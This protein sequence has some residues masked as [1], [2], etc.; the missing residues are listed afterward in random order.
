MAFQ[1]LRKEVKEFYD[2][3]YDIL[4]KSDFSIPTFLAF[5]AALQLLSL[6]YLPLHLSISLPLFWL[7]YR[8]VR[9]TFASSDVFRTSFTDVMLGRYT[10]Q[11]PNPSDGVV[12]FVLGARLNQFVL[13]LVGNQS[14]FY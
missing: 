1:I 3:F 13:L 11:L 14:Y 2:Q 4:E 6:V 5:G 8:L 7:G 12:I 10:A 9:S